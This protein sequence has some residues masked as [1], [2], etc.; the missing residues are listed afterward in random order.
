LKKETIAGESECFQ[1][2]WEYYKCSKESMKSCPAFSIGFECKN[3]GDCWFFIKDNEI[4][5]PEHHGPCATCE[6][7]HLHGFFSSQNKQTSEK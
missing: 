6:W 7:N 2:C 4:G 3:F 5:G 1:S